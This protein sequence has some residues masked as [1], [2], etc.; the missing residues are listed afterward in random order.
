[1]KTNGR[2]GLSLA[3]E[4][5]HDG[6]LLKTVDMMYSVKFITIYFSLFLDNS[7]HWLSFIELNIC[8]DALQYDVILFLF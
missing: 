1:M 8:H 6:E 2:N 7:L 3:V 5:T 4:E